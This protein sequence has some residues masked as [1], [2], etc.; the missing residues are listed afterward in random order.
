MALSDTGKILAIDIG[1]TALK[2]GI[3]ETTDNT[4]QLLYHYSESYSINCYNNGTFSDIHP[5]KWI[6]AFQNG[7]KHLGHVLS[8]VSVI[9][10]SGTTPGLVAMDRE[11]KA[12][13]P[14][15]LMLDLRSR[16]QAQNIIDVVGLNYLL[17]FTGNVPVAGGCSLASIL[18]I[19]ENEPEIYKKTAI[20]GHS[21]TFFAKW[22][23]G[24]C[25]IDPSSA[26]LS[27][28]YNT[29]KNDFTWNDFIAR[30][31]NVSQELLPPIIPADNSVGRMKTLAKSLGF[32]REPHVLIGGNDAVLAAYSAGIQ[33]PGDYIN[34]NGTCEISLVC[35]PS[36]LFSQNYNVR[37]HVV[38]HRW[39]TLHV[40]NAGG[41]ALEWFKSVFCRE[42][43]DD[44]FYNNFIPAATEKW[45]D[46]ESEVKYIP[47]LMG[48]RY[49]LKNLK[50]EFKG[51]TVLSGR[52]EIL[53]A[54]IKGLCRYQ[55]SHLKE[56][57]KNVRLKDIIH[58][59]GGAVNEKIIQAKKRWMWPGEYRY[60]EQSSLKGAA[61]LGKR[62][63]TKCS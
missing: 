4:V 3:F 40:M 15:L 25:A 31:C 60:I 33:E 46:R 13:Y 10:L 63:L 48:S 24:K 2:M 36:C 38:P 16:K 43:S 55:R 27:A 18:W 26:S 37:V 45:L 9:S 52:E 32:I 42:M 21:N 28:L 39:L 41:K 30:S 19:K 8:Q 14:A 44:F 35:L 51:L 57:S 56:I 34:V 50:A 29:V 53:A 47:F 22:L 59:T 61:L 1:T 7:C 58:V 17:N 62:F 20:F 11:G 5:E 12:L 49:S 23:T 6:A 54:M